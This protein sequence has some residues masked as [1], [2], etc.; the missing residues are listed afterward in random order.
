M[1]AKKATGRRRRPGLRTKHWRQARAELDEAIAKLEERVRG[2]T[3][4]VSGPGAD[5]SCLAFGQWV[6]APEDKTT[7]RGQHGIYGT[8]AGIEILASG[9]GLDG[10]ADVISQA[11]TYLSWKLGPGRERKRQFYILLRQAMVLRALG[12]LDWAMRN[13]DE[14]PGV[15]SEGLRELSED[16]LDQLKAARHDKATD[17]VN[18]WVDWPSGDD[19]DTCVQGYRFASKSEDAPRLATIW[20]FHQAAVLNAIAIC[21]RCGLT[22]QPDQ[23]LVEHHVKTLVRWCNHVLSTEDPDPVALRVALFAGWSILGLDRG[24]KP[25]YRDHMGRLFDDVPDDHRKELKR[26]LERAIRSVLGEEALQ[27]DLHLPFLYRLP[28]ERLEG[29]EDDAQEVEYR[30]EHLVVPTVPIMISLVVRLEG[31]LRFDHRYLDL[32]HTV[33]SSLSKGAPPVVPAQPTAANG[34]VNLAY[35]RGALEEVGESLDEIA[36]ESFGW[37][38]V[39]RVRWRRVVPDFVRRWQGEI[40]GAL[41]ALLL[42]A[43]AKALGFV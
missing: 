17:S 37:R 26:G 35:L 2:S 1:A 3:R 41:L 40:V 43:I 15:K 24:Q 10:A 18:V 38:L 11:W 25:E 28:D 33:M 12:A 21:F 14:P 22:S 16:L 20:A 7:R 39:K 23:Y 8:A 42:G 13:W 30:Q 31:P 4:T 36:K 32:L 34:T 29:N 19:P 9:N 5:E 6:G 27:T